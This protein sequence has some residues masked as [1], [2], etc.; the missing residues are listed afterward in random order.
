MTMDDLENKF[1]SLAGDK[2]DLYAKNQI[3][4]NIFN[5]EDRSAVQFMEELNV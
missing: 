4:D 5:C 3:K 1:N 2:F